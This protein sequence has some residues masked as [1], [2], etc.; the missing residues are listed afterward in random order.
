[1]S[2][3]TDPYAE[4]TREFIAAIRGGRASAVPVGEGLR[5]LRLSCA[6][7]MESARRGGAQV[8]LT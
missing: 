7:A 1:M 6:A 4:E 2:S 3:P 8:S 5:S